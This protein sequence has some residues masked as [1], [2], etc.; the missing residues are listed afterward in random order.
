MRKD[1]F[2]I[3]PNFANFPVNGKTIPTFIVSPAI[4]WD[5][6]KL[7]IKPSATNNPTKF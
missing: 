1:L 5:I 7:K 6:P 4:D 3:S 2:S